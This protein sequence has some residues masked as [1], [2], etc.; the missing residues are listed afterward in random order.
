MQFSSYRRM[1]K[2]PDF[3]SI[4][5]MNDEGWQKNSSSSPL[6]TTI[7]MRNHKLLSQCTKNIDNRLIFQC[8]YSSRFTSATSA[9]SSMLFNAQVFAIDIIFNHF[10]FIYNIKLYS[11]S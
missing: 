6:A 8:N 9:W 1:F 5:D 3:I 7:Q 2:R 11:I 10:I 4:Y